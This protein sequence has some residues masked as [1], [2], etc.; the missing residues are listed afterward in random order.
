M[1][2]MKPEVS[3]IW[4]WTGTGPRTILVTGESKRLMDGFCFFCVNLE[5][6]CLEEMFWNIHN[7]DLWENL[8]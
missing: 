5:T 3:E 8:S 4:R 6:L 7:A 1:S 2:K